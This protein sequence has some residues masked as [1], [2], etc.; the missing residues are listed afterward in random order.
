MIRSLKL[1]FT[2]DTTELLNDLAKVAPEDWLPHYNGNDYGGTWKGAA[3]RSVGGCGSSLQAGGIGY[4]GTELLGRCGYFRWVLERF[5]CRLKAVRLLSLAPGS[6]IREHR[7]RGLGFEDGEAR[8]HIPIQ[9]DDSVEFYLMGERL[10]LHTGG[11]FYTNV[12]LPH[13]VSNRGVRDRVHMVIDAEVNDW[14]KGVFGRS[15]R[16]GVLDPPPGGFRELFHEILAEP[17]LQRR[18]FAAESYEGLSAEIEKLAAARNLETYDLGSSFPVSSAPGFPWLPVKLDF[19]EGRLYAEWVYMPER[20]G[21]TQRAFFDDEVRTAARNPFARMFRHRAPLPLDE[22][23]PPAGLVFHMSRCGSTL[24][25]RMLGALDGTRRVSSFSEPE[26]IEEAVATRDPSCLRRAAAALGRGND[27]YFLKLDPHHIHD[28]PLFLET[29]PTTPWVFL[30]RHPLEVLASHAR[31]PGRHTLPGGV[32]PERVGLSAEDLGTTR[33]REWAARVMGNLMDA[34]ASNRDH[35][36][37]YVNY[38]ELP[39]AVESR[40]FPHFGIVPDREELARVRAAAAVDAKSPGVPFRAD[41]DS[42][43]AEA[44]DELRNLAA[45]LMPAYEALKALG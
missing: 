44:D 23:R 24:V 41:S 6:F 30:H 11:C 25:S 8:I 18:L 27:R 7:D 38:E 28:L 43:R 15:E 20:R 2:F 13:R 9:T 10:D 16:I 17:S 45:A 26:L 39:G 32:S 22:S 1:P 33:P 3:L 31:M 4:A 29:F 34:A 14:L 35:L 5:E 36:G 42:K 37:I 12:N 40:V 19:S 21:V